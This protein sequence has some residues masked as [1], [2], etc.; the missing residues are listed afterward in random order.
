MPRSQDRGIFFN[1][2]CGNQRMDRSSTH[3]LIVHNQVLGGIHNW[4]F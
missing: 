1:A 2:Y 3:L 4:E